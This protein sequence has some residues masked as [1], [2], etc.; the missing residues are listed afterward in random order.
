MG[1]K[2]GEVYQEYRQK[3]QRR[4]RKRMQGIGK[5]ESTLHKITN[6]PFSDPLA[7]V[8]RPGICDD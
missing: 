6:A 1:A 8:L 7:F 4:E 3:K 5:F 2:A